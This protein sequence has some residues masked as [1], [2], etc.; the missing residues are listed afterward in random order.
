MK[1]NYKICFF[2]QLSGVGG[3][4]KVLLS[5]KDRGRSDLLFWP[6]YLFNRSKIPGL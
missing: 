4:K 5:D 3:L 2:R 1:V 6:Y